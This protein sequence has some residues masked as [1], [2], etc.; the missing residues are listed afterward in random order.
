M[1]RKFCCLPFGAGVVLSYLLAAFFTVSCD[2]SGSHDKNEGELRIAFMP[3]RADWTKAD[4]DMPDTCDFILTVADS[5]GQIVYDGL[6]GN[7]PES[8]MVKE[9]SYSVKAVSCAFGKP[10]FSSPQYG[11]EQCVVVPR[12]GC[13]DVKLVCRQ[14]NAGIRL[15]IAPEFLDAYPQGALLLSSDDGKLMYSYREKRIAYFNPGRVSLL[16]SDGGSDMVLMSRTLMP[17]EILTLGVGVAASEP[18]ASG[19]SGGISISLDTVRTWINDN[20][21]IGGKPV[22]GGDISDAL[23][24]QQAL[25]SVGE[26]DVWVCGYIVGG[27]LTSASASFTGPFESK[28]NIILGPRSGTSAKASCLS[29]QL[30]AGEIR[31]ALNLVENPGLLGKKVYVCGDIV[32]AYYGI[33]GM[34]NLTGYNIP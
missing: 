6:F 28:T 22:N 4:A 30:P 34:K 18:P 25:A 23:T 27:D 1:K 7:C 21:I 2:L 32:A 24:V 12:G 3:I 11:D 15:K 31:D 5:K 29:I 14:L 33:P 10:A 20:Y 17:Q 13:A 16:L 8:I 9:G 19:T 26:E